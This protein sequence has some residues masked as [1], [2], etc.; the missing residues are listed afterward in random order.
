M[1]ASQFAANFARDHSH[2]RRIHFFADDTAAIGRT[3]VNDT[4][5]CSHEKICKVLDEEQRLEVEIEWCPGHKDIVGNKRADALAK[6]AA[7]E[8]STETRSRTNALRRVLEETLA[9]WR[10]E[11]DRRPM[12]G[13]FAVANHIPPSLKPLAHFRDLCGDRELYG[14]V[15]QCRAGHGFL[16]E[17]YNDFVPSENIDC[18]Y[19]PLC[20]EH[21][22]ILRDVPE[23]ISLAE[24]LG[25]PKGIDALARFLR[26]SGAFTKTG[27]PRVGPHAPR[28]EEEPDPGEEEWKV[29]DEQPPW[30]TD[31]KEIIVEV[32]LKA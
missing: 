1:L 27:H 11:W 29:E 26:K 20:E 10:R 2:L 31:T 13:R 9:A 28:W 25:T 3:P 30:R 18:P 12:T 21:R 8:H 24:I 22:H 5:A 7:E 19:C 23:D 14:R 6:R 17:Y 15:L 16:G 4:L 32:P